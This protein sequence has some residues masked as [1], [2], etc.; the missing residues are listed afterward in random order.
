MPHAALYSYL[1][2]G[3]Y[4]RSVTDISITGIL[5]QETRCLSLISWSPEL[6]SHRRS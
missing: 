3:G 4:K 2:L 5:I 6:G 1:G